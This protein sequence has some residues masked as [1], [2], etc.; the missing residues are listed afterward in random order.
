MKDTDSELFKSIFLNGLKEDVRG[1]LRLHR[2][3]S[4][5]EMMDL[6]QRADERNRA[7]QKT[8]GM[9]FSRGN[10]T[11]NYPINRTVTL[12]AGSKVY[13]S[14]STS[15]MST[16]RESTIRQPVNNLRV[17]GGSFKKLSDA[18]LN[19]K[20]K[21]GLCFSCDEKYKPTHVCKNK[22]YQIMIL[23]EDE[24]EPK[25]EEGVTKLEEMECRAFQLSLNSM[26][27]FTSKR[28]IIALGEIKGRPVQLQGWRIQQDFFI[29]ELGDVEVVLGMEWIA[30]FADI[31]VNFQELTLMILKKGG[32]MVLKGDPP[33]SR[34]A[35]SFRSIMKALH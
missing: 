14:G 28:S 31:R 3:R 10:I 20:R 17:K 21:K 26:T 22:R 5:P 6:A 13:S 24:N 25:E 8:M 34:T 27:G 1:E 32:T 7:L 30:S 23:E 18:K 4:L 11:R 9:G 2:W 33:L 15:S 16:A 35:T 12:D 19:D 29:F